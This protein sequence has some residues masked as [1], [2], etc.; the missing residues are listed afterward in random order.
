MEVAELVAKAVEREGV[1][2]V[3][4]LMGEGNMN[5]LGHLAATSVKP[6]FVRH[7]GSAV[8]MADGYSRATRDVGVA[9]VTCGPGVAQLGTSLSVANRRGSPVVVIGGDL[10]SKIKGT[11]AN[12]QD[13]DQRAY[14]TA[15]GAIF[16]Q[17][18]SAATAASDIHRAFFLARTRRQPVFLNIPID[19]SEAA[20]TGAVDYQ[21]S[22]LVIPVAVPIAPD[23]AQVEK[24]ADILATARR[25]V[26]VV[27]LGAV[28]SGAIPAID[29]LGERIGAAL[30]TTLRAKG[31]VDGQW[32][33]GVCGTISTIAGERLL[34]AADAVLLVGSS[35]AKETAAAVPAG[36]RVIQV[37]VDPYAP[38]GPRV[39]DLN[40]V[41][42]ARLTV[43]AITELL[44]GADHKATGYRIDS[45]GQDFVADAVA[46]DQAEAS[47][48]IPAGRVDHR[49]VIREID[50][51]I[52]RN[53]RVVIGGGHF[54]SF[55]STYLNGYRDRV[56]DW[57]LDFGC[58]GQVLPTAIGEAIGD[59]GRPT[60]AFEGDSSVFMHIHEFETAARYRPNLLLFVLNDGALAAEYHKLRKADFDPELG[61]QGTP[62]FERVAQAFGAA[63]GT[64]ES[65][66][67]VEREVRAFEA[68]GGFRV[69]DVKL[70]V[71]VMSRSYRSNLGWV[72]PAASPVTG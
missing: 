11:G 48:E 14:V 72:R 10:P 41:G 71:E 35:G 21:P 47:W 57:T 40:V 56:F 18:R 66:D 61:R 17:M 1:H 2:S 53:S 22:S 24:A 32:G 49:T 15:A 6:Y 46:D 69:V 63:G 31:S 59:P 60:I 42:D 43:E 9:T 38:L 36:A 65:I 54:W 39:P 44:A 30:A 64:V 19:I 34:A 20:A 70:H 45:Y 23:P 7:E 62:S 27:G 26:I 50:R 33:L 29:V 68:E 5:F 16:Q 55:P 58:I 12:G 51:R 37:N 8:T 13:A 3:F 52:P 25:P 28:L 67:D 4:G